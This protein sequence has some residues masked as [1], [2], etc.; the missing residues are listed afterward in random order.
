MLKPKLV[1]EA[2]SAIAANT[3]VPVTVKC[4]IGVDN[5]DSYDELCELFLLSVFLKSRMDLP[6]RSNTAFPLLLGDF[7]YK[8]STLSPTR[9]F[10]VHS[11]KALL[12]GISPADNRRIPPL[13]FVYRN[14]PLAYLQL[15]MIYLFL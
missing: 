10:I 11:R 7:I 1:G 8:V 14:L 6:L 13:K 12:G 15:C 9:H 2:M 4:R 5:H 3:N